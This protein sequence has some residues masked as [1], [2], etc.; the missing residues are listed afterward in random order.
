MIS[1][2]SFF[3]RL[4]SIYIENC[5]KYI[6]H[7]LFLVLIYSILNTLNKIPDFTIVSRSPKKARLK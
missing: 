3:K 2:T 5:T 4:Y 1:R 7:K 6:G